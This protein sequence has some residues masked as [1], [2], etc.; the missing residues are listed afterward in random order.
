MPRQATSQQS[1]APP[2]P[3]ITRWLLPSLSQ[4]LW[5]V[6]LLILLSQPWRTMMVASDGDPHMHWRVGDWMLEHKTILRHDE[7]SHTR[8]KAPIISKE[9]LAELIFAG[10]GR[11]AGLFGLSLVA[12]LIIATTFALL[13]W[14]LR[15]E[16]NDLLVA[17]A[18]TLLAA[19]ASSMHWL[20]RPHLF[21]FLL[22]V[23]WHEA[24]RR[25]NRGTQPRLTLATM[26]ALMVCWVN[27]HGGFLAGFLVLGAY[28]LGAIGDTLRF[29]RLGIAMLVC[30]GAVLLNPSGYKLPWHNLSFLRSEFL[31]N[32]LAEYS[33][34]SFQSREA[35]GFLV[36]LG[37]LFLTLA[38]RRPRLSRGE[39]LLLV[40][41]TGFAL[42]SRRNIPLMVLLTAPLIAPALSEAVSQRWRAMSERLR[43]CQEHA[44]GWPVV[45]MVA[46]MIV[47]CIPHP[48]ELP[49]DRW[50]ISAV[51]YIREHSDEF[52]GRMFND[53]V[54]GGY[55]LKALPEHKVFV[56]GR[57]DFYGEALIREYH[58]TTTLQTNWLTTLK[59][60]DVRWTLLPKRDRLNQALAELSSW[61][62][63]YT[64]EVAAIYRRFP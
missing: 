22:L 48:T 9:W 64:D 14:Q 32:W 6:L 49:S 42:Y 55:L 3:R 23:V 10:A 33:S 57:T 53:Y 2:F 41:W 31:V 37:L 19:W 21:S 43:G 11:M 38:W 63:V 17:T 26:A 4:W 54:W 5:L 51:R 45:A 36:W 16:G 47:V 44:N 59:S 56:D 46:W 8:T 24:V 28:W 39:A 29:R 7:F 50:P 62:C 20:A 18:V 1:T 35:R 27:L 15:R 60:H 40:S 61:H 52:T 58:A 12:A 13:H 25:M 30:A 34:I